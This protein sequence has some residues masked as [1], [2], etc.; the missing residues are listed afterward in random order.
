M[1]YNKK[2][3]IFLFLVIAITLK[4][5]GIYSFSGTSIPDNT[6]SFYVNYINNVA[7]LI[8]PTLSDNFTE[9][10][11]TKCLNETPLVWQDKDADI[12]FSGKIMNYSIQPV[13]IQNNEIAAKNRLTISVE[14]TYQNKIDKSQNFNQLF[15]QYT[16]FESNQNFPE[17]EEELNNI[18]I[19]NL[20]DDIFNKA[21]VNW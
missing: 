3:F 10:L 6:K 15:S 16:D 14:I 7:D 20:I 5:C 13:S 12:N 2:K 18:I 21:L 17:I 1:I 8:Q 19:T 9:E 4:N 11:K